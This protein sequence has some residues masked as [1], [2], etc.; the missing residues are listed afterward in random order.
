MIFVLDNYDSF[1]YNLVQY[2]RE[3][4]AEVCVFR[5]DRIS[6]GEI[7]AM[8]PD[9]LVISPG[10]GDPSSAGISGSLIARLHPTIPILGVCLGQQCIAEVFGGKVAP[11]NYLMHGKTSK[12]YHQGGGIFQGIMSP[13][14]AARYH[15]LIVKSPLPEVLLCTASTREG[16]IMA[17]QHRSYP[18]FGVQF[19]PESIL[20]TVGKQILKNFL[21]VSGL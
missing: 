18:V 13:F 7:E 15:S 5:N 9:G 8:H 21:R 19:H 12:I 11:A 3:L 6:V 4:G 14:D 16:E 20:T 2:L 1:T 10:P 17:L